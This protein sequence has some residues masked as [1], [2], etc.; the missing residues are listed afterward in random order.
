M[1]QFLVG[2]R[3]RLYFLKC[4]FYEYIHSRERS[5]LSVVLDEACLQGIKIAEADKAFWIESLSMPKKPDLTI[6]AANSLRTKY[7]VPRL[8]FM[9][10]V[11]LRN[12]LA[13]RHSLVDF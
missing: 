1:S 6:A 11:A 10:R 12:L 4:C 8:K 2:L 9:S 3:V 13:T 5:A 7:G